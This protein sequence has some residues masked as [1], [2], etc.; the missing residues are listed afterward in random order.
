MRELQNNSFH[1]NERNFYW[2]YSVGHS[3]FFF[4]YLAQIFELPFSDKFLFIMYE[5]RVVFLSCLYKR[6]L[7]IGD[8]VLSVSQSRDFLSDLILINFCL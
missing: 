5:G 2:W 4:S 7:K 8:T 6:L 1:P 3:S